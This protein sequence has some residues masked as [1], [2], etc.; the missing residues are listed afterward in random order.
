MKGTPA[1]KKL[2]TGIGG[3]GTFRYSTIMEFEN[4]ASSMVMHREER[5]IK[6]IF[7]IRKGTRLKTLKLDN[8]SFDISRVKVVRSDDEP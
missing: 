3:S 7:T 2:G 8:L 1:L 6:V 4:G 5:E